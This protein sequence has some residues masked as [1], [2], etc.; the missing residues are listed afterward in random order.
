M[1][2]VSS[3]G[4]GPAAEG[5]VELGNCGDSPRGGEL[6]GIVELWN[7]GDSPR[8]SLHPQPVY[9]TPSRNGHRDLAIRGRLFPQQASGP[10][11]QRPLEEIGHETATDNTAAAWVPGCMTWRTMPGAIRNPWS[12]ARATPIQETCGL[13]HVSHVSPMFPPHVFHVSL[14][15]S[16][17]LGCN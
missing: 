12:R 2:A 3:C 4:I 5:I 7:C 8:V 16:S 17:I 10:G 9:A 6:W 14:K 13:S 15:L 1:T 11:P